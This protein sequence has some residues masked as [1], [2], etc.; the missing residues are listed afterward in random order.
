M[1]QRFRTVGEK[2]GR[3]PGSYFDRSGLPY[4]GPVS[5]MS[6]LPS[7]FLACRLFMLEHDARDHTPLSP[8]LAS[9]YLST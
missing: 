3:A 4:E 1:M 8:L 5:W 6:Q 9:S 7:V 2:G